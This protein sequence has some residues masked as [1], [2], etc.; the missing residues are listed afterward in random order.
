ML[1][2]PTVAALFLA[3][4]ITGAPAA[5]TTIGG[6][7][8]DL[9]PPTGFCELSDLNPSDQQMITT[10]SGLLEK[11][12]NKLL[13]MSA[14]CQQLT[15]WRTGRRQLLDDYAQYQT[16]IAGMDKPPSES[17]AQTCATLH[18]QGDKILADQLPDI[19]ARVESTLK[20]I[21]INQTNFLGV[22]AEEPGAC[23]AALVQRIRTE[24]GVDKTQV[25]IF[26]VTIVKN[27]TVLFYRFAVYQDSGTLT[28]VLAKIKTDIAALAAANR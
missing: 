3:A 18:A 9:P 27:R 23:Y 4:A 1:S 21:K 11:S 12:G 20:Q 15:D 28:D 14:D 17:V 8:V 5:Q 25:T 7:P 16:I 6:V 26:A 13:A 10:L 24:A 2:R 19:K 22:V